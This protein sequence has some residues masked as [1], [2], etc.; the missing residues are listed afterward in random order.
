[1]HNINI[2]IHKYIKPVRFINIFLFVNIKLCIK[3]VCK[4]ARKR[5]FFRLVWFR[6]GGD[7]FIFKYDNYHFFK[8]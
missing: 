2:G 1:M 8:K 3:W 7:C 4:E 6:L 5:L